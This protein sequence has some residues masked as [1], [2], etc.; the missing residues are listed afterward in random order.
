M[1][2]FSAEK[3]KISVNACKN[4]GYSG[5]KKREKLHKCIFSEK[6]K[7]EKMHLKVK[8]IKFHVFIFV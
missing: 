7:R 5:R 1:S 6:K 4:I 2:I 3:G 8:Y